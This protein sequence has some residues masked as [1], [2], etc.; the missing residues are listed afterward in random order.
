MSK[1][2]AIESRFQENVLSGNP[3]ILAE[4]GG[5]DDG[6]RDERL[7]I[8]RNAYRL[9]LAEVLGNDYGVLH[10]CLGDEAFEA[11]A[12]DYLGAHPSTF[13]NVRWF[14]GRLADFIEGNPRY[15]A[16][17]ELG[18]LARFEWALGLA[19]DSQDEG[20]VR[21]EDVAAVPPEAWVDLRFRP[22]PSLQTLRMR[23]NAVAIWKAITDEQPVPEPVVAPESV[24]WAVWRKQLSPFFRSVEA[25]EAWALQAMVSQASFGELCAGMCE[26]IAEDQAAARAA[27]LLRGWVEEGWIAQLRLSA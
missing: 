4:I 11:L 7:A 19:F 22:H 15:A 16:H 18:E 2:A 10:T 17:P 3:A 26:W 5:R 21:F 25:D 6:F 13:R 14:G 9:R 12:Q 24:T 23:S 1:L 8:Y 20:F 27:G